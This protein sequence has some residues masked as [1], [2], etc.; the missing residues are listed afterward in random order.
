MTRPFPE[1]TGQREC[2]NPPAPGKNLSG[3]ALC[4]K[5]HVTRTNCIPIGAIGTKS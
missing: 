5:T 1:R 2:R 3:A 4:D